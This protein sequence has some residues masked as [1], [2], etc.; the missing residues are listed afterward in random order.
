MFGFLT[1]FLWEM[2]QMPF[3]SFGA[4]P[5]LSVVKICTLA[6]AGDAVLMVVSYSTVSAVSRSRLWLLRPTLFQIAIYLII[7]LLGTVAFEEL[8]KGAPWGW[9]YSEKM[10]YILGT[11][12]A[13]IPLLMWIVIPLV[14]LWLARRQPLSRCQR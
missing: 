7:G 2:W 4:G 13:V 11:R 5:Y 12:V 14:T 3:Y 1:A 8:A 10:P 9:Q 6:S